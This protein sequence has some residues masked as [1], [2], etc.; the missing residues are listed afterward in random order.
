VIYSG[1]DNRFDYQ[2]K[3]VSAESVTDENSH[4]GSSLLSEGTLY[5]AKFHEDGIVEWLPLVHGHGPLTAENG[6]ESQADIAIDTRLAADLLGATP[7]D[8]PED[9]QPGPNGTAYL[10][11]TNNSRRTLEQVDAA[12]PRPESNFGHII[13]IREAGE[14]HSATMG[15]WSIVVLCGD[16][17]IEE[18]GARWNPETSENGWF[19]SPDNCAFDASGRL[20]PRARAAPSPSRS[21]TTRRSPR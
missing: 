14:N 21:S 10:M 6:F 13:E 16:P 19:S 2:Y 5:V 11:L 1:D 7:M 4:F 15:T 17:T 18:V 3:W 8:R 12:N 9:A 20:W